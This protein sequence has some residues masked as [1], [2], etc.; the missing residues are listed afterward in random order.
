MHAATFTPTDG[1]GKAQLREYDN[2]SQLQYMRSQG[3]HANAQFFRK[4][5]DKYDGNKHGWSRLPL[6]SVF[7]KL[8]EE[9]NFPKKFC[10]EIKKIDPYTG[11]TKKGQKITDSYV[12]TKIAHVGA[13][14]NNF[15]TLIRGME[16]VT[17]GLT[18][19]EARNT[20]KDK[21]TSILPPTKK[22]KRLPLDDLKRIIRDL[23]NKYKDKDHPTIEEQ[24]TNPQLSKHL[25]QY[26]T[27][28]VVKLQKKIK[29]KKLKYINIESA[30]QDITCLMIRLYPECSE[31]D[32]TYK[33]GV[34]NVLLSFFAKLKGYS[35]HTERRPS[36]GFLRPTLTDA[37]TLTIR[38]SLGTEPTIFDKIV[39]QSLK[40]LD[41]LLEKFNFE[42]PTHPAVVATLEHKPEEPKKEPRI[43]ERKTDTYIRN[44]V[45]KDDR[46]LTTYRQAEL[47]LNQA[48]EA[49]NT[50]YLE[51]AMESYLTNYV[52]DTKSL[53]TPAGVKKSIPDTVQVYSGCGIDLLKNILRYV[54]IFISKLDFLEDDEPLDQ[55]AHPYWHSLLKL[56]NNYTD[57]VSLLK[58]I[59]TTE[60]TEFY[61]DAT[62]LTVNILEYLISL[63]SLALIRAELLGAPSSRPITTLHDT[64]VAYTAETLQIPEEKIDIYFADS[65]QQAITTS[66][67]VL[68][69][70]LHGQSPIGKRFDKDIHL[71]GSSYFE[72]ADFMEDARKGGVDLI[73]YRLNESKIVFVDVSQL[74]QLDIDDC[75][76]MQALVI[77]TTHHPLYDKSLL[78][79][80]I[81]QVQE[82]NGWVFIAGSSLKH[83]QLGLDKYTVGKITTIAPENSVLTADA[84]ETLE[85]ISEEAIHPCAASYLQ[86]VNEICRDK[87]ALPQT[88]AAKTNAEIKTK[89][90][91]D[92]TSTKAMIARGFSLSTKTKHKTS[93]KP[94]LRI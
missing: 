92:N 41:S 51:Q 15:S 80:K 13:R 70:M 55:F 78:K 30:H 20:L 57:A 85:G 38:L 46:V 53:K 76:D 1:H 23:L 63:D 58:N 39:I 61:R 43:I 21:L 7:M 90:E 24:A 67:M 28:R 94:S 66:L 86:M 69:Q 11:Y 83:E 52:R 45:Q 25:L 49:G 82:K 71:F 73:Q 47:Y 91:R 17:D 29:K 50:N 60:A 26:R 40:E 27:D 84:A 6:N 64:E 8:I 81:K 75:D 88:T 14:K 87:T 10:R 62:S 44:I 22:I 4:L 9:P 74:D 3:R 34:T 32:G 37:G 77:D 54:D 79:T 5:I 56:H 93:I 72:V 89:Q 42:T 65:G 19:P 68:S 59:E 35:L 2:K 31:S 33:E 16:L 18:G 36:F 48:Y 12:M